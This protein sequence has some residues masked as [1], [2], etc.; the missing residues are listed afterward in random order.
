LVFDNWNV[1]EALARIKGKN[2]HFVTYKFPIEKSEVQDI[3]D[4][5]MFRLQGFDKYGRGVAWI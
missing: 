2:D 5:K 1:D 4:S 3:L